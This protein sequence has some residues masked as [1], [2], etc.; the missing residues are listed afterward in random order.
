MNNADK[1]INLIRESPGLND[2]E[3]SRLTGITPR[4]QVN[5][6][7][8]RLENIG[9]IRRTKGPLGKYV[10]ILENTSDPILA[11]DKHVP[12]KLRTRSAKDTDETSS[13]ICPN[14]LEN[15]LIII[16]CSGRKNKNCGA[17]KSNSSFKDALPG[18]LRSALSHVQL[19]RRNKINLDDSELAPAWIRYGGYFYQ[20]AGAALEVCVSKNLHIVILS[21]GYGAIL[22][23]EMI[24]NYEARLKL[25]EWPPGLLQDSLQAYAK[26]QK[27]KYMRAFVSQ[28][29]DYR[30]VVQT[31]D[32]AAAGIDDALEIVPLIVG[33]GGMVKAPRAQGEAFIAL[34]NKTLHAAWQASDGTGIQISRL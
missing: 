8:R 19:A 23:N 27:L 32:W 33:G 14:E 34:T 7:C 6:I 30:K 12:I 5:Q 9:V 1:I 24:G 25:T 22:A 29:S 17:H 4:Q 18:D 21:G 16:P 20:S 15:T 26:E 31:T 3:I 11:K 28:N 10:N 2:D 13:S